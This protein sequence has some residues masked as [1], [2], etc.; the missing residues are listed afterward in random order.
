MPWLREFL[1]DYVAWTILD[2]VLDAFLAGI[3]LSA[4][5]AIVAYG[6]AL[7][8]AWKYGSVG[9]LIATALISIVLGFHRLLSKR[10]ALVQTEARHESVR[11]KPP[12]RRPLLPRSRQTPKNGSISESSQRRKY[13]SIST[14][15]NP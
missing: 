3:V 14:P 7:G 8:P 2:K 4:L 6:R 1:R 13:W 15:S 12:P 10:R 5:T 11:V 9:A